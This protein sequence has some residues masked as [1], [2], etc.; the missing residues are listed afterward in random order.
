MIEK[1]SKEEINQILKELGIEKRLVPRKS[2]VLA[3]QK[4]RI[5]KMFCK[6]NY[7]ETNELKQNG[8]SCG[9]SGRGA[10]DDIFNAVVTLI[11]YTFENFAMSVDRFRQP[12]YRRSTTI[13]E[14]D[15]EKYKAMFDEILDV[16][17]KHHN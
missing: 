5:A 11:D 17:E 13:K 16:I 9:I 4:L 6:K 2:V 12:E 7:P 3:D 14:S 1:F 10:R 8:T 15:E